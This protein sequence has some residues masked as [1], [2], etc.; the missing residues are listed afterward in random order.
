MQDEQNAFID[1]KQSAMRSPREPRNDNDEELFEESAGL[2]YRDEAEEKARKYKD[3]YM[4]NTDR[5]LD[6][7]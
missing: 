2:K 1:H 3:K 5:Q 6:Q 7:N 4:I